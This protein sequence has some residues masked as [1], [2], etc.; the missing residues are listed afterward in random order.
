M[1]VEK[2]QH[3]QKDPACLEVFARLSE[4]I[5]GELGAAECR[6]I[7]EHI[8]DCPPCVEFLKS[9]RRCISASHGMEGREE[10]PPLP[11]EMEARLRDAWQQALTRRSGISPR[12]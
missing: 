12:A 6:H 4:Y 10:C 8:A 2:H 11:P 9:L 5:D 7:E 1:S 3:S